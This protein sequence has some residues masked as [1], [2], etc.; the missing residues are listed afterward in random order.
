ML[1]SDWSSDVCSS[2]LKDSQP[3][4][5]ERRAQV[6]VVIPRLPVSCRSHVDTVIIV[7]YVHA[8]NL[9]VEMLAARAVSRSAVKP[10]SGPVSAG[11]RVVWRHYAGSRSCLSTPPCCLPEIG[12][13]SCRERVCQS[14]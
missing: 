5:D 8:V 4:S 11:L 9:A 3:L 7:F 10:L 12:R 13:A 14:V 1:I 6:P 2:D